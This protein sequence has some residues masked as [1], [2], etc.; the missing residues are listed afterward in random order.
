MERLLTTVEVAERLGVKPRTVAQYIK[1]G[2]LRATRVGR[3]FRISE[4][5]L[6]SFERAGEAAAQVPT[7]DKASIIALAN[8]KG[9]VAKTTTA[10]NLGVALH[11]RGRRVLL[12]DLDP[13]SSLSISA[14]LAVAKLTETIYEL[15]T[16]K[17]QDP[18]P[19]IQ[20][21]R[22][23]PDILPSTIDLALA[24]IELVM[25]TNRESR[26]KRVLSPLRDLYDYILIDCPPSLGLL[27]YNALA[28][29]D[30]VLIP[31]QA[32]YLATRGLA[33]L[34]ATIAQVQRDSNPTL[35]VAGV[36]PTMY[37]GRMLH[38]REVLNELR[39][40][41]PA[42]LLDIVVK[43]SVRVEEAPAGGISILEYDAGGEVAQ[44]YIQLA[45]MI[46]HGR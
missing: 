46:D 2:R 35:R 34:Q 37:D 19:T 11:R 1:G 40:Y 18:L 31:V 5:A 26:L 12:V 33:Q 32:A 9:G 27:T 17:I 15:L 39:E 21:T 23:G 44:A 16:D 42:L 25:M 43:K 8:Q 45:E 29:A 24:E 10:F 20:H 14:G 3:D 28:C 7:F 30:A 36:L 4:L 6:Q 41:L 13:Q 22:S 38:S